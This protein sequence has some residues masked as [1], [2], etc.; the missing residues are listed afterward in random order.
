MGI[1]YQFDEVAK[2]LTDVRS[3]A[4]DVTEGNRCAMVLGLALKLKPSASMETMRGQPF[5]TENLRNQPFADKFFVKAWDLAETVLNSWGPAAKRVD[6]IQAAKHIE[7][8]KGFVFLEDCW[9]TPTEKM[10]KLLFGVDVK[11]GDH[12]DLWD[13][14]ALAIYPAR[15]DSL[16]LLRQ[17][18][19]VWFWECKP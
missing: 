19:K 15:M 10:N 12:V 11:S 1:P 9:R 3:W 13:G 17:S 5:V 16:G 4:S 7:G 2:R 6:G 8:L 14:T 18:R